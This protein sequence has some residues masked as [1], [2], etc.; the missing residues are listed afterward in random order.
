M[1]L[2]AI[3]NTDILVRDTKQTS[4]YQRSLMVRDR[5]T[6]PETPSQKHLPRDT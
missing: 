6:F 2:M 3:N 1:Q 4:E 5:D